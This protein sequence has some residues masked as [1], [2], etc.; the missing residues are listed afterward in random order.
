MSL[1]ITNSD[2]KKIPIGFHDGY[3]VLDGDHDGDGINNFTEHTLGT[4]PNNI[5]TDGDGFK[6]REEIESGHDPLGTGVLFYDYSLANR[7]KGNILL[8]VESRGEAWYV[9]P[10]DG[11]RYY[12][13]NGIVAYQMMRYMSLGISNIDLAKIETE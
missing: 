1:G 8:Q 3:G 7:L 6:D 9:N 2:L 13:K 5:D 10:V 4:D 12:M 11:K